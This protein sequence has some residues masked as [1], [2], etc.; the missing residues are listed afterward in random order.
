MSEKGSGAKNLNDV[1][2]TQVSIEPFLGNF[3]LSKN[4]MHDKSCLYLGQSCSNL[5]TYWFPLYKDLAFARRLV[6]RLFDAK[7]YMGRGP[8]AKPTMKLRKKL[9]MKER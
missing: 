4:M 3:F 1:I 8:S 9:R 2:R 6:D 5:E 7:K